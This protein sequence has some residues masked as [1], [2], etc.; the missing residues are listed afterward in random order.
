M[1]R[2]CLTALFIC[3]ALGLLGSIGGVALI[4]WASLDL[5]SYTQVSD[6][7]PP[8]ASTVYAGD[9]SIIGYFYDEKRF[10]VNLADMPP[11]LSKAFLAAEDASFYE[12]D[13]IN[14]RAIIRAF[15]INLRAGATVH[16]G[17]TI[18]QQLV[19]RLLLTSERS[20]IRK[21]KEAILAY[22]L[23]RYL[24]KDDILNMYL[25][26]IF[27]GHGSY[28]VE[29]AA[30]TYFGK[31]VGELNLAECAVLAALPQAPSRTNPF[32]DPQATRD[33]QRY[34]LRRM[35]AEGFINQQE[36]DAALGTPLLY[37]SMPDPSWK[38]GAW[39]LEEVRRRLIEF[40]Q[41]QNVLDLDLPV[42]SFGRD[43]LYNA[44]LH[45]YTSMD[46]LHQKAAE[47]ALRQ[48]LLE[49]GK[50]H[51]WFGPLEHISE[52]QYESFLEKNVFVPQDFE[53]AGWAKALVT[54]VGAKGAEAR[55]GSFKGFI[56]AKRMEWCRLPNPE[57]AAEEPGQIR[58]PDKVLSPG[59]VVWVSAV[60]ARGDANPV[61]YPASAEIPAYD[62]AK[63]TFDRP[64]PLSLEQAPLVS[65]ALISQDLENGDVLA[66]VG[67]YEYN[68]HDQYN[69]ATQAVRQPGSAFKPVV[70]SAALDKGFTAAS[71]IDDSPF[72]GERGA[73]ENAALWRPSN[74]GGVFYGPTLLRTALVRSR[75][76]CTIRLAQSLG[77]KA[78]T[79][80]AQAM[81]IAG[82]IPQD[83]S[84]SLGSYAVTPMTLTE[85]YTTFASGGQRVLPRLVRRITDS[86][87]HNIV[88][89]VP[90]KIDA[91]SPLNAFLMASLLKDVSVDG[92]ARRA[93]HLTRIFGGKTGT[94][95]EERDA[96]F[97]GFSPFLVTTVYVGYDT[98]RPMGKYE[99][100][101]RVAV[102]IF[103]Q[104]R[105]AVEQRYP[106]AD[107]PMPQGIRILS[108]DAD[109]GFLSGEQSTNVYNLP[110]IAG[111]EPVVVSGAALRRGDDDVRGAEEIFQQ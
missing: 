51:G 15:W 20:Y 70:Y 69:R 9:G 85:V 90:E 18:T 24:S 41:E 71:M 1:K 96:W 102:P 6:Y 91:I 109:N 59:D 77:I 4:Y 73:E 89:F 82:K 35:L 94:S 43:V 3:L 22:R 50:R 47:K 64:I 53:N 74:Y 105:Q 45:I 52:D 79:E 28:G 54:K 92:T 32:A 37:R 33:R 81:G 8:Q 84:I 65:G 61:G 12:H 101:S 39:Y 111:T 16:G 44:G 100:G 60:G 42:E 80:R 48:G 10:L 98:P 106:N 55:L 66:L 21:L 29:A 25:N 87:G 5:P 86:W 26:Q 67:G 88:T 58:S 97:V 38:L 76:V 17:S 63:V 36:H 2:F 104:Y 78:I 110:F 19:K 46:P 13:G 7:R 40:F 57:L 75:N 56:E 93:R 31:H 83:L 30:R 107:F 23:E 49:T 99:T 108:I 103:A 62:P 34:V 72:I 11:H 27:F 95:N 68:L 14:P